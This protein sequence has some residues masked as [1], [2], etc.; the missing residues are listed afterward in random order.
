[1]DALLEKG[2]GTVV[3]FTGPPGTGKTMTAEGMAHRLG[4]KLHVADY[5]H[6]ESKWIG[7][8]EKNILEIF[9][10]ARAAD[11]VLL[12][13]EA[14]AILS[15]RID[16]GQYNDRA[17]NRQVSILLGELE[18]FEGLVILTTNRAV[19][20]DEALARRVSAT[21]QFQVPGPGERLRIWK[22]LIPGGMPLAEDVDLRVLAHRYP[23]AG[24][25]IKNAILTA[26][27]RAALRDGE[28]I[29]VRQSDLGEAAA[30]ERQVF[31]PGARPIGFGEGAFAPFFG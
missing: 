27:R 24:G 25:H 19:T 20:L 5:A 31:R 4:K 21:F 11:A 23:L 6:L 2:K 14:D 17:Y 18:N 28:A 16:G 26:V 12:L 15:S 3:L 1:L 7:E 30:G 29:R 22:A 9:R 13:D 8:T 10:A